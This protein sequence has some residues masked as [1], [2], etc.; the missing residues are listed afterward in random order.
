MLKAGPDKYLVAHAND[1]QVS[2]AYYLG[3]WALAFYLTFGQRKL[4]TPELDAYVCSIRNGALTEDAFCVLVGEPLPIFEK[5]FHRYL[6]AL[7]ADGTT[8]R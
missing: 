4:G 3:S 7:Q 1:Q 6:R 8:A 2:D 5:S